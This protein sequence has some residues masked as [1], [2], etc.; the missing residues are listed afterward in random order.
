MT[1]PL[2]VYRT[3][4][5]LVQQH[6][7][8]EEVHGSGREPRELCMIII[9]CDAVHRVRPSIVAWLILAAAEDTMSGRLTR[10]EYDEC[11]A[12][13]FGPTSLLRRAPTKALSPWQK[14]HGF[15][16]QI[17]RSISHEE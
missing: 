4:T 11:F 6:G 9:R 5:L 13:L 16:L 1:S 12:T 3:A 14:L 8:S 2:D 15:L 10:T 7:Q 17:V